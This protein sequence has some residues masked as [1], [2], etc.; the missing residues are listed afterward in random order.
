MSTDHTYCDEDRRRLRDDLM[1]AS[2]EAARFREILRL[3]LI[4]GERGALDADRLA[5]Y[6]SL[7]DVAHAPSTG[8]GMVAQ[9]TADCEVLSGRLAG[10]AA[11]RGAA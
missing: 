9:I 6:R 1:A 2:S 3:A 10:I 4:E 11:V 5:F 7:L 8:S